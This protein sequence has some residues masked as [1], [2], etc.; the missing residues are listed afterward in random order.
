MKILLLFFAVVALATADSQYSST[1]FSDPGKAFLSRIRNA[2]KPKGVCSV[3]VIPYPLNGIRF[4]QAND[5]TSKTAR[6]NYDSFS[7]KLHTVQNNAAV[8]RFEV[9]VEHK[10]PIQ[11]LSS[12]DSKIHFYN[13]LF[14]ASPRMSLVD[15]HCQGYR[16][17]LL[18][19]VELVKTDMTWYRN[20]NGITQ[21]RGKNLADNDRLQYVMTKSNPQS[22][23]MFAND[24][25]W[26]RTIVRPIKGGDY[27]VPLKY[28]STENIVVDF[29]RY[30]DTAEYE[31]LVEKKIFLVQTNLNNDVIE[32]ITGVDVMMYINYETIDVTNVPHLNLAKS[33]G[34]IQQIVNPDKYANV[35]TDLHRQGTKSVRDKKLTREEWFTNSR[36]TTLDPLPK[37]IH[38]Y[39][40]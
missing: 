18:G 26:A 10:E 29:K 31:K 4:R 27:I 37:G 8:S 21:H 38:I 11:E 7:L 32:V 23:T 30:P 19:F 2:R 1:N 24:S 36:D 35:I 22:N 5:N 28:E 13:L 3:H 12:R 40:E 6:A 9:A 39:T 15:D 34:L 25:T 14:T 17:S 33:H 20:R 16:A